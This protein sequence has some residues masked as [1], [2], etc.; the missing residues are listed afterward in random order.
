MEKVGA[1]RYA[2]YVKSYSLIPVSKNN[3]KWKGHKG[4]SAFYFMKV[5]TD[6]GHCPSFNLLE[7]SEIFNA[8]LD[9]DFARN[10]EGFYL[11]SL[12]RKMENWSPEKGYTEASHLKL[13][14]CD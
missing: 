3:F 13:T 6:V 12:D 1:F 8:D 9:E 5:M 7:S 2:S 10:I 14:L 4:Q 11:D